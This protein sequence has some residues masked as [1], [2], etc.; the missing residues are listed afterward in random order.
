MGYIQLVEQIIR[1]P[2]TRRK[3]FDCKISGF[4]TKITFTVDFRRECGLNYSNSIILPLH[5]V[6]VNITAKK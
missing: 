2:Y 1:W 3:K 6:K 4:H 5:E